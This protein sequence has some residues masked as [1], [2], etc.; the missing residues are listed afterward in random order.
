MNFDR[1]TLIGFVVLGILLVGYFYYTSSE[2]ASYRKKK[3][4]EDSLANVNTPKP[5][6][7]AQ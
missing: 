7:T 1:N 5:D 6:T 2:Q 3:A 4:I